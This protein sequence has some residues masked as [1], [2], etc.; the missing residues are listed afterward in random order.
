[1]NILIAARDNLVK[2]VVYASS[3]SVYGDT[4]VLPQAE[5]MAPNPQSPYAVSKL[6]GEQYCRVFH[7]VYGLP[8]VCLR[9]FN[10]YG[11]RQDAE[12][13]YAAVIPKFIKLVSEGK[14]PIIFGDGEQTRDF[15]F[16]RDVIEASILA[17][18]GNAS[19]IFNIG[20]G[21]GITINNLAKIIIKLIAKSTNVLYQEAR[22]G[23]I[24][25]SLADISRAKGIGYCPRYSLEKGLK[26]LINL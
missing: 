15:V 5:D 13:P 16:V 8:T 12:S 6:I 24:K 9:Y 10:V 7:M 26:E 1:L 20:Y 22:S 18:E 19:G 25:H 21:E 11:P 23:E 4:P 14:P 2:K 3:S 17:A